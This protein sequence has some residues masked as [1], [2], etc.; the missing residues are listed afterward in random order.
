MSTVLSDVSFTAKTAPVNSVITTSLTTGCQSELPTFNAVSNVT[1]RQK[2]SA[3]NSDTAVSMDLF[4]PIRDS[5][6]CFSAMLMCIWEWDI[7]LPACFRFRYSLL[8][9]AIL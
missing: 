9:G 5:E 4:S 3:A 6:C 7:G 2:A 8:P 1:Q